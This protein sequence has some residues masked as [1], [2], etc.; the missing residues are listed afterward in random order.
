MME[1]E[2]YDQA[3]MFYERAYQQD[4]GAEN[5]AKKLYEARTRMVAADLIKVR[6]Q[7]QSKQPEVAATLLNK[8]LK[9]IKQ[10]NIIAD[11]A[12]KST[13]EEEVVTAGRWLN[14]ELIT[15]GQQKAYNVFYFYL[16][17]Y[18]EIYATGFA[19]KASKQYLADMTRLG[20]QQCADMKSAL[21][22]QSHFLYD[23]WRK[24]CA[25]MGKQGYY[26]LASDP[27]R[28]STVQVLPMRIEIDSGAEVNPKV[29]AETIRL[30]LSNNIWFNSR[31]GQSLRL[32]LNG[33]IHYR[34][35]TQAETFARIYKSNEET[36]EL[37]K[38]PQN[39]EKVIR[40]LI[41]KKPVEKKVLFNGL[42]ITEQTSHELQLVGDVNGQPLV[43]NE[44]TATHT[45]QTKSHNAYF[46]SEGI[47]P[48]MPE[49]FNQAAWQQGMGKDIVRKTTEQLNALWI[50]AYC[51]PVHTDARYAQAEYPLRCAQFQPDHASVQAWSK[52][53]FNL[54]YARLE[55]LLGNKN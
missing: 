52:E 26:S 39:P 44:A 40:A 20:Q 36:F 51:E 7:R 49:F 18:D 47:R 6:L 31:G 42:K 30:A 37:I 8:T 19:E 16:A 9:R 33:Q 24:Y 38:D 14:Q 43:A 11:S 1:A 28:Y 32:I 29:V 34:K 45:H 10:W 15:L 41:L 13:I 46:E 12:V 25:V 3:V 27:A 48:L 55:T 2:Q 54:T 53:Q 4:P 35:N 22:P 50:Q 17:Q 23:T 5:I 21:T